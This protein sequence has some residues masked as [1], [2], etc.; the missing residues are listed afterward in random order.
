M[1]KHLH[2][3]ALASALLLFT[4]TSPV[5]QAK[6]ASEVYEQAA[7][8]TVVVGNFDAQGKQKSMG[9]GVVMPD[10]DVVTNCHVVKGAIRLTVRVGQTERPAT[11]RYSDWDRDV[12][13]LSSN[14]LNAPAATV[15]SSKSLKVGAKVYAIG[16]PKG[17]ELTLSDGIVSS[18]RELDGGQY[19]QTTAA[20]S[21]G[22]SGGGLY[23]DKGALVGLT[24]FYYAE[25]QS[26]NFA[27][28]ID[29]VK[30]LPKRS[31]KNQP[32]TETTTTWLSKAMLLDNLKDLER[33]LAHTMRWTKE[34]P[35]SV[36]AWYGLGLA[37]SRIFKHVEA[38][39]ALHQALK[40]DPKNAFAW[41]NLG[42]SYNA[43]K[44]YVQ[45][46][47]ALHQAL[48]INPDFALAWNNLGISYNHNKQYVQGKDALLKV[49]Q[50]DPKNAFAW[51]NLGVAYKNMQQYSQA[52]NAYL[53]AL[54]INP[55]DVAAMSNLGVIYHLTG[56]SIKVNEVYTKL[57]TI[58]PAQ[59]DKFFNA[60][61]LPKN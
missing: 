56:D 51:N 1:H 5:A 53:E 49:L 60:L 45:A 4:L 57:K 36:D 27:V 22:S 43:N 6:T 54:Q 2:T 50:I 21:P 24:T 25:G 15:G 19:I 58:D 14:G 7:K 26:L 46:I 23:D 38:I 13:S 32:S 34:Q 55:R 3:T 44:Q 17:L 47:D 42:M 61:I 30:D 28:P 18:L 48:R 12:C 59:A 16:A 10:G 35:N 41:N 40:I 8:S 29:W 31:L 9:S 33:L 20:I 11:L 39:D 52:T 37:Y